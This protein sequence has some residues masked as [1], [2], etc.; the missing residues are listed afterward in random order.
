MLPR[1]LRSLACALVIASFGVPV[2]GSATTLE[3]VAFPFTGDDTSVRV[4]LE[5]SDGGIVFELTVEEGFGDLRGLFLDIADDALLTALSV[6]GDDITAF[7]TGA[8]VNLGG[9]NNLNGGGSPCPCEIGVGFGTPGI[10]GD[11]LMTTEFVLTSGIGDLDLSMFVDQV[12]GV[13]VTSVGDF[14]DRR[15]GSSKLGSIIP[16]PEPRS[17]ALVALGLA[18]LGV[19]RRR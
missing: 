14:Q 15:E 8:V 3:T 7:E 1:L 12:I 13:R 2:C 4:R 10:G 18:G 16:V 11:D 9:G 17:A 5:E 6:Q 19:L